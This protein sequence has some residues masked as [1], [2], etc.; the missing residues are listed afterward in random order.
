MDSKNSVFISAEVG[1][2]MLLASLV[3]S[4]KNN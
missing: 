3:E 2:Y 4:E 1:K